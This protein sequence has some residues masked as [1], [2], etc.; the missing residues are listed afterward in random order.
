MAHCIVTHLS[1]CP[2]LIDAPLPNH[3]VTHLTP[4]PSL[5]D[6]SFCNHTFLHRNLFCKPVWSHKNP[7]SNFTLTKPKLDPYLFAWCYRRIRWG[8][9]WSFR[10]CF[11]SGKCCTHLWHCGKVILT[12]LF[13][14]IPLF[15]N[16]IATYFTYWPSLVDTPLFQSYSHIFNILTLIGWYPSFPIIKPH[17]LHIVLHWLIPLFSSHI[18]T[19]FTYCPSLVDTP[20]FQSYSHIFYIL[21]FIV[22]YPLFQS[23]SDIFYILTFIGWYP[24]FLII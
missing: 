2:L 13:I 16:H 4:C 10:L 19:Y 1:D 24:S 20:L 6:I 14:L 7:C 22:W 17:I 8:L 12:S 3:I 21:T 11:Y 23:Y 15:S 5:A 18:A 9:D